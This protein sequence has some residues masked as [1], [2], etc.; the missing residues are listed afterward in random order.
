[1]QLLQQNAM[2]LAFLARMYLELKAFVLHTCNQG[3]AACRRNASNDPRH[4]LFTYRYTRQPGMT[5]QKHS[6]YAL[7]CIEAAKQ[8][9]VNAIAPTHTINIIDREGRPEVTEDMRKDSS[10]V[11]LDEGNAVLVTEVVQ[12]DCIFVCGTG[13]HNNLQGDQS[14]I[15]Y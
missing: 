12:T 11:C 7:H 14:L 1:M 13:G 15:K 5:A 8:Q 6:S 10:D 9:E 3:A 4:R 2:H